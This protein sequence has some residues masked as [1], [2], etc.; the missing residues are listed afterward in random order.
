MPH[1][2][3]LLV[4][5][6]RAG[7]ECISTTNAS[8]LYYSSIPACID[9]LFVDRRDTPV[10]CGCLDKTDEEYDKESD[11]YGSESD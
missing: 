8:T 3:A 2:T 9:D 4:A 6:D 11:R 10:E 1:G 5:L 7:V